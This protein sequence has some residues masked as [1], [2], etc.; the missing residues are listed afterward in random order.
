M[1]ESTTELPGGLLLRAGTE[2]DAAGIVA[3]EVAAFGVADEDGVRAHL[4]PPSGTPSDWAVVV[5]GDRV[6]A[7]S[8]L[9]D[10]VFALD[11]HP[12]A[13]GQI[14]YVATDPAYRRRGLVRAQVDWHHRRS[15]QRGQL[16]T[17]IGGIPY[18]YRRF[19]YG[20]GIDHP[21][22]FSVG[23]DTVSTP[24]S[25]RVRPMT[26]ADITAMLA[27]DA[28]R[29]PE[30]LYAVRSAETW[31]RGL[32]HC[33]SSGHEQL[34]VAER[35]GTIVGWAK[36]F[37]LSDEQ[38]LLLEGGDADDVEAADALVAH[39][40]AAAK[41]LGALPL[42]QDNVLSPLGEWVRE[43]G[44]EVPYGLG[45]Y[46]RIPDAVAFLDHFRPLL[47]A[48]LAASELRERDGTLVISLY[49]SSVELRY[50]TGVVTSVTGAPGVEDPFESMGVGIAPDWFPALVLGRWGALELERRIDDVTLG[51]ER[52]LMATLFPA[53][54]SD[55]A[56]DL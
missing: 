17:V 53:R 48:R 46:V 4:T 9:I 52:A 23:P 54:P 20:Y 16:A 37:H 7:A 36:L 12:F 34:V 8:V 5:D 49:H 51:R 35:S 50:E 33:G 45:Y 6:V 14:E 22:V 27:R 2:A 15:L 39:T 3:V 47:S 1:T 30:G 25:T 10:H 55:V 19:G 26:D 40:V 56:A 42:V 38:R 18:F 13:V 11:G 29:P 21:R 31:Q 28:R 32:A 24:D 43:I 44:D 41:R